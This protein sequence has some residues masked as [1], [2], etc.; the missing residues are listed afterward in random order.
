M[1]LI[2]LNMI[3]RIDTGKVIHCVFVD[4]WRPS[5][6]VYIRIPHRDDGFGQSGVPQDSMDFAFLSSY[7]G[8]SLI[9]LHSHRVRGWPADP[10]LDIWES[11]YKGPWPINLK[12]EWEIIVLYD[13]F[14][15]YIT[16][17]QVRF[18]ATYFVTSYFTL[19][20]QVIMVKE[21]GVLI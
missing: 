16:Q 21:W 20:L 11:K 2:F 8:G 12:G 14:T 7:P 17:A 1:E 15:S 18:P 13:Q 9:H 3:L 10:D 5:Y 19:K 4:W 6:R